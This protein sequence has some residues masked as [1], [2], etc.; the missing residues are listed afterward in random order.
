MIALLMGSSWF[1]YLH[2][3]A[4]KCFEFLVVNVL[5]LSMYKLFDIY[6]LCMKFMES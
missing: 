2:I 6:V 4:D 5:V 3:G 1:W